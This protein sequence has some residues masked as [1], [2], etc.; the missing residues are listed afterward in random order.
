MLIAEEYLLLTMGDDG[1][2]P[3]SNRE[4]GVAGA[5]LSEL[6][7][8]ERVMLDAKGRIE[9]VDASSTGDDV[10]DLALVRLGEGEGRKPQSV[11][12]R[13]G[14]D[15]SQT[16]L[17]RLATAEVVQEKPVGLLGARLWSSWRLVSTRE[18]DMLRDELLRVVTGQQ[19]PDVRTGSLVS[20]V[21]ATGAWGTALPKGS[22]GGLRT[23]ELKRSAKEISQGRWGS[24][25]VSRAIAEM[26]AAI[27]AA[28]AASA[29]S[30]SGE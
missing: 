25:A 5:L 8:M 20:L 27:T 14:K 26:S 23:G 12:G 6:A 29:S 15:M 18:L 13:L 4:L 22:R 19:Q 17:R 1:Y 2:S 28:V 30:G 24:E 16:L 21:Q 9:V 10:L 7:A 11:L 3:V